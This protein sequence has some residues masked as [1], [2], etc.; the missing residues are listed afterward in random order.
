MTAIKHL[1][2]ILLGLI[3]ILLLFVALPFSAK[4]QE[5]NPLDAAILSAL[6]EVV[7]LNDSGPCN[8][9]CCVMMI[10]QGCTFES[11]K[12]V[13]KHQADPRV[14][15]PQQDCGNLAKANCIN[16]AQ[17]QCEGKG[18]EGC[19]N[20]S[21]WHRYSQSLWY[22]PEEYHCHKWDQQVSIPDPNNPGSYITTTKKVGDCRE[23]GSC[24]PNCPNK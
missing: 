22:P 17:E 5:V 15:S 23:N 21:E 7:A 1:R 4:G 11:G 24:G 18:E 2:N 13:D 20:E 8:R 12:C 16:K 10:T 3:C 19:N 6:D 14:P 9:G